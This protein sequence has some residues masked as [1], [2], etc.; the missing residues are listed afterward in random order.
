LQSAAPY[1]DAGQLEV[2]LTHIAAYAHQL[3]EEDGTPGYAL[4]LT[5]RRATI[6]FQAYG[7]TDLART[8]V[9][10]E[11]TLYEIGSIGKSFTAIVLSQLAAEGKVDLQAPIADQLPLWRI[12]SEFAPVTPH[13]LLTHTSGL[14]GGSDHVPAPEYELWHMRNSRLMI[15][16]NVRFIYSNLGY[17]ALGLLIEHVTGTPYADVVRERIFEP[18]RLTNAEGAITHDT[19]LRLAPG[20]AYRYDDRPRLRRHGWVPATWLETNTGDGCIAMSAPDLVTYLRALL[21]HGKADTGDRIL[22]DEQF[23]TFLRPHTRETPVPTYGYGIECEEQEGIEYIKHEGGMIGY[24]S[25]MMGDLKSGFGVVVLN[26]AYGSPDKLA[27][28]ALRTLVAASAGEALPALPPSAIDALPENLEDYP[29]T[30]TGTGQIHVVAGNNGLELHRGEERI[31]LTWSGRGDAFVADHPDFELFPVTF[32]RDE[33]GT[34]TEFVNGPAWF[35]AGEV[36]EARNDEVPAQWH[37]FTGHYRSYN[38]WG[39]SLRILIRKDAL[40]AS[41][42]RG[43][44][45]PLKPTG[46]EA[47]F[48]V[49]TEFSADEILTFTPIYEGRALALRLDNGTEFTRVFTP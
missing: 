49:S 43:V 10:T 37:G 41:I 25:A 36:A 38:P 47:S 40:Y 7:H 45:V 44:E 48:L 23:A 15:A 16:P 20:Y 11:A 17:K 32:V 12:P 4:A 3:L 1:L 34:I 46:D 6:A 28:F 31:P 33:D 30:Y 21:N 29:G 22:T 42:G 35:T 26:N 5:D 39:A 18:L 27:S 14:D 13:H 24:L 9:P 8:G 19:R 2:A